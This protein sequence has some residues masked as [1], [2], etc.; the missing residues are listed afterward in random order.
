MKKNVSPFNHHLVTVK[1]PIDL[2]PLR[3]LY[4]HLYDLYN[5]IA[6]RELIICNLYG[7]LAKSM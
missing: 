1:T 7:H 3:Y 2:P 4:R 5:L 6:H